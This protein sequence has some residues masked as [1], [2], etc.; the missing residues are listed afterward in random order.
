MNTRLKWV[1]A[2]AATTILAGPALANNQWGNYHWPRSSNPVQLDILRQIGSQWDSAYV[3]AV[4]DWE[5]STV[6]SLNP[7]S[8]NAGVSPK[9]CNPISG[10][11]LVCA[12][13]YG[14]RG[15]LGLATIWI[16]GDHI[17][18]GT[19]K[20]NDSYHN[21]PPYNSPAWR[22][23]VMCQEIGHDFGLDHQ[24][25]TFDNANLGT[26]QDY[27]NNP[28]GPPSNEHPNSHDYDTLEAM[29]SHSDS[30]AIA[31]GGRPGNGSGAFAF[32]EVGNGPASATAS[33]SAGDSPAEWG[34]AIRFDAHG[35][36]NVYRMDLDGNRA[37]ITHVLWVPGF[38]PEG[39]R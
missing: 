24:D 39:S 6:L 32:R 27:T 10:K 13:R 20:L 15:W 4:A 30:A 26:C 16:D 36:P 7:A 34:R 37:K 2:A 29:Y 35:R 33:G 21:S 1:I 14:F 12:D 5:V 17:V 22:S 23:L 38:R 8:T 28:S 25:E 3:T 31:G 11:I 18:Q 9:R 19:T